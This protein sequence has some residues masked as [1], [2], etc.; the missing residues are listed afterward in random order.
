MTILLALVTSVLIGCGTWLLMQRRLTRIILGIGLLGHGANMLLITAG[1]PGR[2]PIID[3]GGGYADP[4]P[5][6]LA[7]TAVVITFG[8]T[9]F[10][11][12]LGFRSWQLTSDDRVE[13]D[14]EDRVMARFRPDRPEGE[15]IPSVDDPE[16]DTTAEA[17]R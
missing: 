15:P 10:L 5:Q 17:R 3:G 7:L 6:A 16:P 8:V 9:A 4:L 11:L 14:V 2:A 1:R 13:D 12:A